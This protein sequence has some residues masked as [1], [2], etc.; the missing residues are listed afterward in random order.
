MLAM[1]GRFVG[2]LVGMWMERRDARCRRQLRTT[3]RRQCAPETLRLLGWTRHRR[4]RLKCSEKECSKRLLVAVSASARHHEQFANGR[5]DL[6]VCVPFQR[7]WRYCWRQHRV[8]RWPQRLV[9]PRGKHL[10]QL[11][12][13]LHPLVK[14]TTRTHQ[15]PH[16][17][18]LPHLIT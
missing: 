12:Q 14:S 9:S 6:Q 3:L 15:G 10:F 8:Q 18:I 5:Q 11:K 16:T 13:T 7:R 4:D 1:R 2:K 17:S